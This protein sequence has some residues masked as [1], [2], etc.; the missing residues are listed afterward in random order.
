MMPI[1]QSLK[2]LWLQG[3]AFN[4]EERSRFLK[5][6]TTQME[7]GLSDA[8]VY[9]NL[10]EYGYSA[11]VR[12]LARQSL[13][14]QL[15]TGLFT[16]NWDKNGYWPKRAGLL[17]QVAEKNRVLPEMAQV[18]Q[19]ES[20]KSLSFFPCV[21]TPNLQWIGA[22]VL[23][24]AILL[25]MMTQLH[26]IEPMMTHEP[27]FAR[28]GRFLQQWGL[29]LVVLGSML[30]TLHAIGSTRL[31]HP[32][33]TWLAGIG[34]YR[35][36]DRLFA[37]AACDL[38]A[39][40]LKLGISPVNTVETVRRIHEDQPIRC[41]MLGNVI[42]ELNGGQ[43]FAIAL[44]GNLLD[45]RFAQ[46]LLSLS[47]DQDSLSLSRGLPLVSGLLRE[48]V[49]TTFQNLRFLVMFVSLIVASTIIFALLPV[50]FGEGLSTY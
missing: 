25:A 30:W 5:V 37:A 34:V 1:N 20:E 27:E 24:V 36:A 2:S 28:Y 16:G 50:M 29:A 19:L 47:P 32:W 4:A 46:F 18:L 45:A 10:A 15:D 39:S 41:E 13:A 11:E 49:T 42:A 14:G 3:V 26:L 22:A 31:R 48:E 33:R 38:V 43:S 7:A 6:L 40:L 8:K 35:I 44:R 12:E 21:I 9:T 23:M 17:L